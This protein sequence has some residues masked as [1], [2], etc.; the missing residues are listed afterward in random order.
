VPIRELDL[1]AVLIVKARLGELYHF[2]F[3]RLVLN[4]DA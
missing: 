2:G 4:S 3:R 1:A